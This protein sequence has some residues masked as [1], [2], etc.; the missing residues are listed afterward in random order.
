MKKVAIMQPTYLPW[1]GYFAL[2]SRV[3]VF[4]L[5]DSVQFARRSWQQR[6]QIKTANGPKFLTVPVKKSGR[7]DQVITETEINVEENALEKHVKAIQAEYKK[8]PFFDTWSADLFDIMLSPH[9]LIAELNI[10]LILFLKD[11]LG[12]DTKIIRSST[13]QTTGAKADLLADIC[14]QMDAGQYVSPLGS[15]DYMDASDAFQKR[16]IDVIY[17]DYDHPIYRQQHAGFEPFMSVVD[18]LFNEG[19]ASR[20][21]MVGS[22]R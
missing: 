5:F 17:H 12:I 2:M 4:V 16:Q 21:I 15:K 11:A 14:G 10:D 1:V 22:I 3:D 20:E 8:S 6:N 9:G 13:L 19:P 18:L 7:R